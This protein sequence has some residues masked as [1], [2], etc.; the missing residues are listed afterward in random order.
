[1][2]LSDITAKVKAVSF[3]Y[4][5]ETVNLDVR[6]QLITPKLIA[7][8]SELE[9]K[10]LTPETLRAI[11]EHLVR[12]VA[13]WDVQEDDGSAFPLEV[14]RLEAEIPVGFQ[15]QALMAAVNAMGESIAPEV[16][17]KDAAA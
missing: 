16:K 9:E 6:T 1:M 12:L 10:K 17:D 4:E 15:M 8:L 5:G 2:K 7:D 3:D 14:S 13:T 11:S